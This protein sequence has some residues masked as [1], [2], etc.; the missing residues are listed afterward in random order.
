MSEHT[1]DLSLRIKYNINNEE[2]KRVDR[3]MDSVIATARDMDRAFQNNAQNTK[4]LE[5]KQKELQR[6][7]GESQ[8]K[9]KELKN[10][11][12]DAIREHGAESEAVDKLN[13]KIEEAVRTQDKYKRELKDTERQLQRQGAIQN[14]IKNIQTMT[15]ETDEN[16]RSLKNQGRAFAAEEEQ[17]RG[18]NRVRQ[19]QNRMMVAQRQE[20]NR[21]TM[22]YGEHDDRVKAAKVEYERLTTSQNR[23]EDSLQ[24]LN[25][26]VARTNPRLSRMS[27][28]LSA[29]SKRLDIYSAK[30]TTAG[31][32]ARAFGQDLTGSFG[33]ATLAGGAAIGYSLKKAM[34]F[35]QGMTDT[36]ALMSQEEWAKDGKQLTD[37]VKEQGAATKFSSVEAALGL[38][39]LVKA[40]VSTQNILNGGLKDGLNLATAGGLDLA[41]AAEVM[42]TSLNA[43][44]DKSVTS[45]KAANLLAGAANASATDVEEMAYGL[46]QS[47]AVM[48]TVGFNLEETSTALAMFAQA[49]LKGSDAGT[50]LKT[51]MLRLSPQT[52]EAAMMMDELGIASTNT[53]AGYKYLTEKGMSPTSRTVNDLE[54][55]FKQLAK[56]QL[57][58]KATKSELSKETD[59]LRKASGYL[60]SEF[61]DQTGKVKPLQ[62]VFEILN[63]STKNL[64]REQKINALNTMFGSDAIR[65]AAIASN[66]GAKGFKNMND[67][68]S[69]VTAADVA[70]KKMD[71]LKGSIEYM[72]GSIETLV[73]DLGTSLIPTF[74]NVAK[75]VESVSDWFNGLSDSTKETIAKWGLIGVAGTAVVTAIGFVSIGIGGLMMAFGKA[76]SAGRFLTSWMSRSIGTYA[77]STTVISAETAAL[78]LNAAARRSAAISGGAPLPSLGP[79]PGQGGKLGKLGGTGA[80]I[81]KRVPVAGALIGATMIATGGTENIGGNTGALAGGMAG[82]ALGSIVPGVGTAIGGIIGGI[83]GSIGGEKF[84]SYLQKSIKKHW[85]K[86]KLATTIGKDV[87][88]DTRVAIKAYEKLNSSATKELNMLAWSSEKIT[89]SNS[90]SLIDNYTNMADSIKNSM[91]SKFKKTS[92]IIS[93][94]MMSA[95]LTKGEKA[96]LINNLE[97]YH[98]KAEKAVDKSEKKIQR[99]LNKAKKEKRAITEE[100]REAITKEQEKMRTASVKTLSKSAKEQRTI[101]SQL[102]A[103]ASAL[104]V[105]QAASVVKNSK[106][107]KDGAVKEANKKYKDVIAAADAEYRDNESISK[108]QYDAIVASAK[109]TKDDSIY[110]AEEMHNKVV[111]QAKKQAA[112]HVK[113]VDWSTGEM[114]GKW[115]KFHGGL[116]KIHDMISSKINRTLK[117]FGV[118][119]K[120]PLWGDGGSSVKSTPKSTPSKVVNNS[121]NSIASFASGGYH[122]GGQAVVGEEGPEL[123]YTPYGGARL[124]GTRGAEITNLEA[125]TRVLTASQTR[126][127]MSGGLSGQMPGYAKGIGG[128][129]KDAGSA[130]VKGAKKAGNYVA[131]KATDAYDTTKD[132]ASNVYN[133][134]KDI[135]SSAY[136]FIADPGSAID[137]MIN[138]VKFP[139]MMGLGKGIL[140]KTKDA[141]VSFVNEKLSFFGGGEAGG[142]ITN[143]YN[144]Y[145][146]LFAVAKTIMSSPLGKGLSITS[147]HREGDAHDHGKHN[148]IDLSGFGSNGGYKNVAKWASRLPGVGY[149]IG[150]N[151]VYGKKYGDGKTPGW[152]KGHMN[153]LHVS[154]MSGGGSIG[155]NASSWTSQ[156]QQAAKQMKVSLMPTELNGIIAQINRESSGNAGIVQSSAVND[157]NMRN[158]NPARGLL[159]YIPSTFKNYA[160]KGHGNIMSGYDQLLAFFNNSSWRSDLP[161][162]RS[163][164]GPKGK[165]RFASGGWKNVDGQ[166][167]VGEEGPEL[168]DLPNNSHVNNNTRTNEILNKKQG[169]TINFSP[170]INIKIESGQ[171]DSVAAQVK[172]AVDEAMQQ[173]FKELGNIFD[174]GVAY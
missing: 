72:T 57:G 34:D 16:V 110:S 14:S 10:A 106:K 122:K 2:L 76:L 79:L 103:D 81:G 117:I 52:K 12:R 124:V 150:D 166:V 149:T 112:G 130:V 156:I 36:E 146:S 162:G 141:A 21:L 35:E 154:G 127:M 51:M 161:Y 56:E 95:K 147:G 30:L 48:N 55:S 89:A 75:S 69:G 83:A 90:K 27:D 151:I 9:V 24:R 119:M 123:A 143:S 80:K 33:V 172:K 94:A 7:L 138:S 168:V 100:E 19:E 54:K 140:S 142:P 173:A 113:E 115:D 99:I 158:G 73:T 101:M 132:V 125:G 25:S 4:K 23:T 164:W 133:G 108:S 50:S 169:N 128:T 129:L 174:S 126:Q 91:K 61:F 66:Q 135:A 136:D 22:K 121:G 65:A 64:S 155:G 84:G 118:D 131:D 163:G 15:R 26:R 8:N 77:R 58:A 1:R 37:L 60:S 171:S 93:D 29:A 41:K 120:I 82:A 5:T 104:S 167:L 18:L 144:V 137:K 59:R 160:V 47:A 134:A 139:D 62:E 87:S 109:K 63:K 11:Q 111:E 49:G 28:N 13:R 67:A 88:K 39:E 38:Q 97:D 157:I 116:A 96:S 114:L 148:A 74:K 3:D 145:D 68:M 17:L 105:K 153:H 98:S 71:T 6:S 42:S 85:P 70:K 78:R 152:A 31:N 92:E 32:K 45:T 43:F 102:K 86:D 20:L 53:T 170:V 44:E 165:R 107:A 40:G 46:S 159:Q